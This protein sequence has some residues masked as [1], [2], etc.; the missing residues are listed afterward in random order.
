MLAHEHLDAGEVGRYVSA[1]EALVAS[2]PGDGQSAFVLLAHP[3]PQAALLLAKYGFD[4]RQWRQMTQRVLAA[5]Q[6]A[7]AAEEPAEKGASAQKLAA[8]SGLSAFDRQEM[9]TLVHWT[10]HDRAALDRETKED[11]AVIAPF[12]DRLDRLDAS[13]GRSFAR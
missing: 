7:R 2:S 8:G 6:A 1:A 13:R 4:E 3:G 5:R 9:A 11:R 10:E 12:F